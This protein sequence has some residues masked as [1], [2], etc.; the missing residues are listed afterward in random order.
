MRN[1][2]VY[3]LSNINNTVLYIGMTNNLA[4]RIYEHK[5]HILPRS[6]TSRY[7]VTKLVYYAVFDDPYNALLIE[8]RLKKWNRKWKE[9]LINESNPEWEELEVE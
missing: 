8:S 9:D 1:Y 5:S 6:F 4:R 3:I 7:R 2:F